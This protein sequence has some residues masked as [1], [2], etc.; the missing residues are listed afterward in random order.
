MTDVMR[1][2]GRGA[3]AS[4]FRYNWGERFVRQ[5]HN[6]RD[7]IGV[8]RPDDNAWD[9]TPA[10]TAEYLERSA[11]VR[12]ANEIRIGYVL[13]THDFT[14]RS[15]QWM[16]FANAAHTPPEFMRSPLG[17]SAWPLA[18]VASG[19]KTILAICDDLAL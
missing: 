6:P 2:K 9:S 3:T 15:E 19:S 7:L 14:E 13:R 8:C 17:S 12:P 1:R 18:R 11:R 16:R 10:T 5:T 4:A